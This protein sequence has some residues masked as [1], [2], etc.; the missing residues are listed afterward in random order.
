MFA[1]QLAVT[2]DDIAAGV[3]Q[4]VR[5]RDLL[6]S[7]PRQLYIY[8]LLGAPAP[9]YWHVPLLTAPDGRRLSK[10]A[11][12]LDLGVLRERFSAPELTGILAHAAGILYRPEPCTPRELIPLFD[13]NIVPS[14]DIAI[15]L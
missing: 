4:V 3:T 12:D 2:A 13:W 7:T 8:R 10:R 6:S 11:R 1:Y 9:R 5:G 14:R 15:A